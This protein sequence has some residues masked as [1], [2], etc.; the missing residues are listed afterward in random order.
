MATNFPLVR[1]AND[2]TGH[3]FYARTHGHSTMGV[4]TGT[5]TVSTSFDVPTSMETGPSHLVVV[6]DGIESQPVAVA[7]Q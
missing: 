4:A 2:A 3:V 7:V 5:A 1:L 6:A